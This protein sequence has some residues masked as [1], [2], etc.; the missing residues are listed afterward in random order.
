MVP[1]VVR[2]FGDAPILGQDVPGSI[3]EFGYRFIILGRD[4]RFAVMIGAAEAVVSIDGAG[5][6]RVLGESLEDFLLEWADANTGLH[7]LDKPTKRAASG[8][9]EFKRWLGFHHVKRK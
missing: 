5:K 1:L 9:E 7:M 6:Q 4:L 8:H 3:Q 2:A